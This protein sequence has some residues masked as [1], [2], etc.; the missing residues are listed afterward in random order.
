MCYG[1]G[2]KTPNIIM[3]PFVSLFIAIHWA[4]KPQ[5][6]RYHR[7]WQAWHIF[8]SVSVKSSMSS[9]INSSSLPALCS[10]VSTAVFNFFYFVDLSCAFLS[11]LAPLFLVLFTLQMLNVFASRNCK[12][13]FCLV[14]A[15][16]SRNNYVIGDH[17]VIFEVTYDA[18]YVTSKITKWS[19]MT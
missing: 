14:D 4:S 2:G 15:N 9:K 6:I 7:H 11:P 10:T 8:V 3:E 13:D 5:I 16:L 19:P 1:Y 17:F 18:S 12:R